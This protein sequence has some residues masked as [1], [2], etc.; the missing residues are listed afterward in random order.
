[1]IYPEPGAGGVQASGS[2][3][4]PSHPS[5]SHPCTIAIRVAAAD[6]GAPGRG[7]LL[8]EVGAYAFAAS[9][10]DG[11]T[12]NVQALLDNVSLEIDGVCCYNIRG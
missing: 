12:T 10:T 3:T 4:C 9:H 7:S 11:T 1:M 5:A 8:E 6:V 2:V